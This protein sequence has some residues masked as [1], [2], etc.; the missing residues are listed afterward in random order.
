MFVVPGLDLLIETFGP[1][2]IP[3]TLFVLGAIGYFFLWLLTRSRRETYTA[4][5]D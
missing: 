3:A 1:F 5:E 4:D 2:L